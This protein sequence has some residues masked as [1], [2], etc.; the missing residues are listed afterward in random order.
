ME[1]K[2]RKCP[3]GMQ[4]FQEIIKGDFLYVDKTRQVYELTHGL[5]KYVFLSRPRRFGK[6]LLTSTLRYYFEG[7]KELFKGL[8]IDSLETEWTQYP[9]LHFDM[10]TAKSLNKQALEE[11]LSGKLDDLEEIWGKGIVET[12]S[13][14]L[15]L[16]RLIKRVN[17]KTGKQVV[18]LIDEYD[19]PL[20]DVLH[21]DANL[22]VLRNVMRNFYSPLK[23]CDPYLRFVFLTGITKFTQL[24][25]FSELNNIDNVSMEPRFAD[26]CGISKEEL[27]DQLSDY[28]DELAKA[29]GYTH[30]KMLDQLTYRYDGYHFTWPSPDI[31]NPYSLL[32]ALGKK[33]LGSYWFGSGTPTF[34]IEMLRKFN[35]APSEIGARSVGVDG[36][37]APAERLKSITP[38]LYQS[39][40]LTIK[41]G[42]LDE[43]VFYLDIPN[44]EIRTGLYGSLLPN[45]VE[46]GV[47]ELR[48]ILLNMSKAMAVGDMDTALRL[49][50]EYLSSVPYCIGAN[51]EGHYQQLLYIIFSLMGYYVEVEVHTCDGRVD[52]V[53]RAKDKLYLVE[54]K[55]NRTA[56]EAMDQIELKRYD[57]RFSQLQLPITKV[58]INFSTESHTL[59]DWI[60]SE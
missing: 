14:T 58:A 4:D 32:Y 49:L 18:V 60:I 12:K 30:A 28:V 56:E 5:S 48:P 7:R 9:V 37:D 35:V 31:F 10:S 39:G 29:Y 3:L 8:A 19:S 57:A 22:P 47:G 44:T 13:L 50:Q 20:L 55:I 43:E 6:T 27:T 38:L 34:L 41:G 40:Y 59:T 45:Y 15:R 33:R 23:A 1:K 42:D 54:L 21:E 24:S 51:T 25:I 52:A 36:F 26:I 17:A 46:S 16:E 2:L 11:E 53:I